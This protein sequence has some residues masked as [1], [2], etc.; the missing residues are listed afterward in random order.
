MEAGASFTLEYGNRQFKVAVKD[1]LGAPAD[2]IVNAANSGLSHGGG[3]AEQIARYAGESFLA[4]SRR[5]IA[6]AGRVPLTH[7][8]ITTAGNLPYR[9]IIHAVGPRMTETN[10]GKKLEATIANAMTMADEQRW[11]SIAFPALS[12]GIYGV[13]KE[14]CARAFGNAVPKYW[15]QHPESHLKVVW[16]CLFLKDFP[17][18]EG[19]LRPAHKRTRRG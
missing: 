5:V 4:D 9:G 2:A 10:V 13:P 3:V 15:K 11:D 18:F 1:L 16:L 7:C 19:V 6:E 14:I 12:T 17:I 8:V